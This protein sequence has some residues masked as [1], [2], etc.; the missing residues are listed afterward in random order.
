MGNLKLLVHEALK[1]AGQS[2]E[3]LA[4]P[5]ILVSWPKDAGQRK[6]GTTY[7]DIALGHLAEWGFMGDRTRM[8]HWGYPGLLRALNEPPP[9]IEITLEDTSES[10]SPDREHELRPLYIQAND[11]SPRELL[12]RYKEYLEKRHSSLVEL[13]KDDF[14]RELL[15]KIVPHIIM[16][17]EE[18]VE[19]ARCLGTS[20]FGTVWEAVFGYDEFTPALGA[21]DLLVW[22]PGTDRWFFAEVKGPRDHLRGTQAAWVRAHWRDIKGRFLLLIAAPDA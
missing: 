11:T 8:N 22:E 10:V 14:A 4:F 9:W 15:P 18:Q 5:T 1:A 19:L 12:S 16:T 17:F 2:G 20:D 6:P 7:G 21:P 13:G 3:V